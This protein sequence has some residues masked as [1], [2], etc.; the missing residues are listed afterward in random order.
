MRRWV[1]LVP[2]ECRQ[3]LEEIVWQPEVEE[4]QAECYEQETT[5]ADSPLSAEWTSHSPRIGAFVVMHRFIQGY[6][7]KVRGP[8][9]LD[10]LV[11][12]LYTIS[13]ENKYL[14][15]I[16]QNLSRYSSTTLNED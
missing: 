14:S 11:R 6:N 15:R 8:D 5:S 1:K 4:H 2:I 12:L 10:C 7:R 16:Y 13:L 3:R 9:H